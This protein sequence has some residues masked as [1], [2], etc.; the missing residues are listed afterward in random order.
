MEVDLQLLSLDEG[1]GADADAG[2]SPGP[3]AL[4]AED[5]KDFEDLFGTF[6]EDITSTT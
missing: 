1:K 4:T 5:M 6:T 3:L 2:L